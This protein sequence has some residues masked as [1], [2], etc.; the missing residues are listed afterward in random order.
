VL[1]VLES[2]L[3]LG[4]VDVYAMRPRGVDGQSFRSLQ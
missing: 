1:G 4:P 2:A 3:D